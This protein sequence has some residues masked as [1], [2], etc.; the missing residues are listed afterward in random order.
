MLCI[1]LLYIHI[2][3]YEQYTEFDI[4]CTL[5]V[6]QPI[7]CQVK[8]TDYHEYVIS[9]IYLYYIK[10]KIIYYSLAAIRF[11]LIQITISKQTRY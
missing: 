8:H 3:I 4:F 5:Y 1:I 7:S 2:Y 11:W 10:G 6:P 9:I